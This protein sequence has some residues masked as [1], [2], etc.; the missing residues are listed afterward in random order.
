M[1]LAV[2]ATVASVDLSAPRF[3]H[4]QAGCC[5]TTISS[6]FCLATSCSNVADCST[7]P[8]TQCTLPFPPDFFGVNGQTC[9]A[10][11]VCDQ[12]ECVGGSTPT[13]APT[14][15][16]TP[17]PAP[18]QAG[19]CLTTI[20]SAFCLTTSCSDVADCST[21]PTT[22]CTLPFPPDFFGV[23]GQT[24]IAG[25]V[26]DQD[27][28]VGGFTPTTTP[29]A[30][31]TPTPTGRMPNGSDCVDPGT[32]QSGFCADGVC[33]DTDCLGTFLDCNLPGTSGTCSAAAA[34]A[35]SSSMRGL[36]VGVLLLIGVAALALIPRRRL[37]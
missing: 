37:T 9:I 1:T 33:C 4:A 6:A 31:P 16:P 15:A 3:A 17:T 35:P 34:T 19:C 12:N 30:T 14:A 13:V 36:F 28:C 11:A 29:A 23:D 2:F 27:Q 10:G 25:A 7:C 8:T 5:L 22:L 20:S 24:C 21:C 32:C 26:C 18:P